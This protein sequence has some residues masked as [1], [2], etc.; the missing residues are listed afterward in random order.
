MISRYVIHT[1]ATIATRNTITITVEIGS[2]QYSSSLPVRWSSA[3]LPP[4]LHI[5]GTFS[6]QL[7][8]LPARMPFQ[9]RCGAIVR[10]NTYGKAAHANCFASVTS[11]LYRWCRSAYIQHRHCCRLY[12][13]CHQWIHW[14]FPGVVKFPYQTGRHWWCWW[15]Y[16]IDNDINSC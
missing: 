11:Q 9:S 10:C 3:A 12:H 4:P 2:L 16:L 1:W 15:W 14:C 7:N 6:R 13:V 5:L 8:V